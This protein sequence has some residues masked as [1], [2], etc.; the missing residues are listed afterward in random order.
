MSARAR[1]SSSAMMRRRAM[2]ALLY[3]IRAAA[4]NPECLGLLRHAGCRAS[5]SNRAG[6]TRSGGNRMVQQ[7]AVT[8]AWEDQAVVPVECDVPVGWS[9]DDYRQVRGLAR[10]V[11]REPGAGWRRLLPRTSRRARATRGN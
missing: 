10:E 5:R 11:V 7:E 4:A 6:T 8:Q 1:A 2:S 9:L 3:P